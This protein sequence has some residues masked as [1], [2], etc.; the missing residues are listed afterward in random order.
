MGFESVEDVR[1]GKLIDVTL[2]DGSK[3]EVE[4]MAKKLL[5]NPVIETFEVVES[6]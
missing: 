1:V 6:A 4:D 3:Q 2:K 5:A